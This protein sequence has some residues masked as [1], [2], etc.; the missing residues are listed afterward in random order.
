MAR[1]PTTGTDSF[2]GDRTLGTQNKQ[3][4]LGV[5]S[6]TATASIPLRAD[7]V[8][9]SVR[10]TLTRLGCVWNLPGLH[11]EIEVE[12]SRKFTRSLGRAFPRRGIVTLHVDLACAPRRQLREVLCHEAAHIAVFRKHGESKRPHGR[13]W[14][15]LV[16]KAGYKPSKSMVV[17]ASEDSNRRGKPRRYEHLCPVCQIVR[18]AKKPMP[19]WRCQGCINAGLE[20][21]LRIRLLEP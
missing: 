7:P 5:V 12:F 14:A 3:R 2:S 13:E 8:W 9:R 1:I 15:E 18:V 16:R 11:S 6:M 17:A 10:R 20:G 19:R 21:T 4:E